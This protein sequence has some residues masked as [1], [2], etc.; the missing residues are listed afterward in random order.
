MAFGKSYGAKKYVAKH[1]IKKKKQFVNKH[2]CHLDDDKDGIHNCYDQCP[3]TPF[4]IETDSVGCPLD[5]DKDGIYDY[6]DPTPF[7]P[8]GVEEITIDNPV[9]TNIY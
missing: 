2:G 8:E 5:T 9:D 4:G 6:Q 1:F 7:T 3:D